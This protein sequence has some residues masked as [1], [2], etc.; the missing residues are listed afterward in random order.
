MPSTLFREERRRCGAQ[1]PDFEQVSWLPELSPACLPP[2]SWSGTQ[3][4]LAP[5]LVR[6]F[7]LQWRDRAG[8]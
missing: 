7:R 2:G 5:S 6:S 1:A 4:G 8:L 3:V